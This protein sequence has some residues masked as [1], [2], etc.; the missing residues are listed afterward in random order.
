MLRIRWRGFLVWAEG[1]GVAD[2]DCRARVLSRVKLMLDLF[3]S[4]K[5][6]KARIAQDPLASLGHGSERF[7]RAR[8]NSVV[9]VKADMALVGWFFENGSLNNISKSADD[10]TVCCRLEQWEGDQKGYSNASLENSEREALKQGNLYTGPDVCVIRGSGA[11]AG[12]ATRMPSC[13]RHLIAAAGAAATSAEAEA[14]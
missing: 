10:V 7:E 3:L 9:M 1:I 13:C 5:R 2:V 4:Q 11:G 6:Q 12:A 8:C 14:A